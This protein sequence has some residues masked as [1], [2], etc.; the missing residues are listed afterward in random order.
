M[1]AMVADS[2]LT[3]FRLSSV[4]S[5]RLGRRNRWHSWPTVGTRTGLLFLLVITTTTKN[6]ALSYFLACLVRSQI[7]ILQM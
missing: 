1:V 3:H 2:L 7:V 5:R 4:L 6:I